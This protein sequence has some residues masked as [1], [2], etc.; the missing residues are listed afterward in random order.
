MM[1]KG[2][3]LRRKN[4]VWHVGALDQGAQQPLYHRRSKR[5]LEGSGLSVSEHPT[6]WRK[7]AR[8]G[9]FPLW[10]LRRCDKRPGQFVDMLADEKQL[11]EAAVAAG[12]LVP[13]LAWQAEHTDEDGAVWYSLHA[14]QTEAAREIE[15]EDNPATPTQTWAPT[16]AL[17]RRWAQDF[18]VKLDPFGDFVAQIA[19]LYMLEDADLDIDGAWWNEDLDVYKLSAPRGVIFKRRLAA[20]CAAEID[21][22]NAPDSDDEES[23]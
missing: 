16:A 15:D 7:I 1:R 3:H 18:T 19:A 4:A 20:W 23:W 6:A 2:L 21:W 17:S 5:S 11:V 14:T 8:L 9:G 22:V 10:E 13:R 12:L